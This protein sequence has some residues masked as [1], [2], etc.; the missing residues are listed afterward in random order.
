[1]PGERRGRRGEDAAVG[2]RLAELGRV[3]LSH[4]FALREF[5]HS[6]VTSLHGIHDHLPR[7]EL[8]IFAKLAAFNISWHEQPQRKI[9]SY[10]DPRETLTKPG[11]DNQVGSHAH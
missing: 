9:T 6:E 8:Q 3:R 4:S 7:S 2:R 11:M 5:L 1:M 10:V